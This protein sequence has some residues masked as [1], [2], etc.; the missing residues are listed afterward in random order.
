MEPSLVKTLM[1]IGLNNKEARIYLACIE[2][3]TAP[4]SAIAQAAKVNRVTTYD[5]LEKLKQKGL[6]S[7]FTKKQIKYF[8][9]TAP[10]ILVE[11]YEKRTGDLRSSLPAFKRI[12][13]QTVHPRVR[14]FEGLEGI[15][16]VYTDTLTSKTDILNYS[17]SHEIRKIWPNYDKEY[18]QKRAQKKIFLREICPRDREGEIVKNHDEKYHR[19]TKL[20][21]AELFPFTNEINIYDDKVS[22]ISFKDEVIGMIIESTE[23][24]NSQRAIFNLCWEFTSAFV[25]MKEKLLNPLSETD[26]KQSLEREQAMIKNKNSAKKH[27]ES[28]TLF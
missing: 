5:I 21:P 15:K 19:E 9:A 13:G 7:Y 2:K 6:V 22:I 27:P 1:G 23:I 26:L 8:T 25:E 11:E 20:I 14:Y 24:A 4:V 16:T 12:S 10:D 18:V 28:L 17:N 3:G